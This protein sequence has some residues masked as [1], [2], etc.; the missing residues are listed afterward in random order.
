MGIGGK[1]VAFVTGGSRGIGAAVCRLLAQ[2][3]CAVAVGYNNSQTQAQQLCASLAESDALVMPVKCDVRSSE[4]VRCAVKKIKNEFGMVD[5]LVANAGIASFGLLT[6]VSDEEW[7]QVIETN[8]GG[9]FRACRAVLPDMVSRQSGSIVT[10]S[11][12]WGQTGSACECAY[13]ASKAGIIGLSKALAQ[14]VAPSG[15]RVNCV[16]PGVVDTEMN[17]MLS[18]ADMDAIC[19]EIPLGCI[20][21]VEEIAQVIAFLLSDS[22]SYITGQVLGVNG[23]MVV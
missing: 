1:K 8:L 15:I 2:Q 5:M 12:M 20:G 17:S 7:S 16:A 23:G 10:V 9:C 18:R 21:S 14:E 11:S 4:S 22:A 3:G 19:Q 13:S 6:D